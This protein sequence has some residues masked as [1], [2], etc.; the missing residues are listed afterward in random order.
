L[1]RGRFFAIHLAEFLGGRIAEKEN[2]K[3]PQQLRGLSAIQP[4]NDVG[5]LNC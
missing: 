2:K 5:G 1:K 3:P 4:A